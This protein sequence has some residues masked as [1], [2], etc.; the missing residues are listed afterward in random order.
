MLYYPINVAPQNLSV[1]ATRTNHLTFTFKGDK[2]SGVR[3]RYVD[4]NTN[5]IAKDTIVSGLAYYNDNTVEVPISM[6]PN[7]LTNGHDY[8]TEMMLVQHDSNNNPIYDMP[9]V[10]GV[11]KDVRSALSYFISPNI[12]SIYQWDSSVINGKN[13][14]VPTM[15]NNAVFGG[16]VI[17]IG[18]TKS[19]IEWYNPET[20]EIQIK[21][22]IYANIGDRYY[23]YANYIIT[24]QYYFSCRNTPIVYVDGNNALDSIEV[25]G[26]Y[27]QAQNVGIK[28][29][30]MSLY[31]ANNQNF[32][33]AELISKS[34]PT[35]SQLIRFAFTSPYRHDINNAFGNVD[36]YR[37]VCDVVTQDGMTVTATDEYGMNP[38]NRNSIVDKEDENY[39]AGNNLY[40]FKL[41]YNNHSGRAEFIMDGYGSNVFVDSDIASLQIYRENLKTGV[42]EPI[43]T[44]MEWTSHDDRPTLSGWDYTVPTQGRFRYSLVGF[45]EY[46]NAVI[47]RIYEDG[48]KIYTEGIGN[49]PCNDI[50]ISDT[51]YYITELT[52]VESSRD[53]NP[54]YAKDFKPEFRIGD[55]WKIM[56][57]VENTTI[58]NNLDRYTQVGYGKYPETTSTDVGYMS[59]S[60]SAYIGDMNCASGEF[61]ND[62]EIISAWR[63]FITQNKPFLLRS[64]KGDV[65]VVNISDSPT[66]EYEEST[67]HIPTKMS[68]SWIEVYGIRDIRIL[69]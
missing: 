13:V 44:L 28:T 26:T 39:H 34:E 35:Y 46:G 17:Q 47:P 52:P 40:S 53:L 24:P 69:P 36:F 50:E 30:Q 22:Y 10:G 32:A 45:S 8:V 20:G 21:D 38:I 56:T 11:V 49:F 43:D 54:N 2:M 4:Y 48:E 15:Y 59:G 55:T 3:Y 9:V 27:S 41:E 23:I 57:E 65:W 6:L 58:T 63:K 62:I 33:N 16:M 68:F 7:T 19:L 14:R 37:I 29:Y 51:A 12:N 61:A 67:P 60:L 25:L 66:T 18:N 5:T 42:N 64:Q 1:D 31:W